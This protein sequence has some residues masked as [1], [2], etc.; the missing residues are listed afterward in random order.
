MS[1]ELLTVFETGTGARVEVIPLASGDTILPVRAVILATAVSA[2]NAI[3]VAVTVTTI[4]LSKL[5]RIPAGTTL[6]FLDPLT[7]ATKIVTLTAEFSVTTA[8]TAPFNA[9][10]SMSVMANHEPIAINST[11]S[12]Y[13]KLGA[14]SSGEASIKIN[15][16]GLFTFDSAFFKQSQIISAEGEIKCSGAYSSIDAGTRTVES[17][18]K[19]LRSLDNAT[20]IAPAGRNLWVLVTTA[21]P[22]SAFASGTVIRAICLCTD[23]SIKVEAGKI[24]TQDLPFKVNGTVYTDVP[25]VV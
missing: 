6:P 21:A 19:G 25:L 18:T 9:T 8:A 16:E 12:N 14:R 15:D 2:K 4:A 20:E 24:T 11:S 5:I 13:I 23:L 22:T 7:G 1:G 17:Q 3:T 10:G